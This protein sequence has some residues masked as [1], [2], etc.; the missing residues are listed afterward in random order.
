MVNMS[1]QPRVPAAHA[2]EFADDAVMVDVRE[3]YEW[4]A[5][6]APTA[7]H[8]PMSELPARIGEL[9]ET[10]DALPIICRSG[11][12]SGR[13]V[14]WLAQQGYDAVNVAGGMQAWGAAGKPMVAESGRAPQVV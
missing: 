6:H 9:P 8:I 3:Q 11:N 4:D 10:D 14:A 13:V 2:A 12:R 7:V 5:G 1:M